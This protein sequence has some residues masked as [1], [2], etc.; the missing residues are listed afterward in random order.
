ME[1]KLLLILTIGQIAMMKSKLLP[2]L[3]SHLTA[4]LEENLLPILRTRETLG[5]DLPILAKSS[6]LFWQTVKYQW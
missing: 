5:I 1:L 4:V 6:Y 2:T 3:T